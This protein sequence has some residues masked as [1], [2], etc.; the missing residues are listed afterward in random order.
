MRLLPLA[1]S[2]LSSPWS[3]RPGPCQFC[4]FNGL[5]GFAAQEDTQEV[6][7]TLC[8]S[9]W[10]LDA[11]TAIQEIALIWLPSISQAALN[12]LV[13]AIHL[14]FHRHGEPSHM[15][16]KPSSD[17]PQLRAAYRAYKSL[18]MRMEH[19]EN[20]LG[21]VSPKDLAAALMGLSTSDYERRASLLGGLRLL[22][23]GRYF[24]GG[25]DI[26]PKILDSWD[27]R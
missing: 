3:E 1:P 21:L 7:C 19:V 2:I 9:A 24:Q 6:A 25:L 11:D 4:G 16:C 27:T 13:R 10:R 14:T 17:T 18:A 23:R 26:Y 5:T 20:T 12:C 15:A 8:Q 22:H